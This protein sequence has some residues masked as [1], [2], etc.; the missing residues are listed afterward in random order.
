MARVKNTS[1]PRFVFKKTSHAI[2]TPR[3]EVQTTP[4]APRKRVI[5]VKRKFRH[6]S[7]TVAL[8]EIRKYQKTTELLIQKL[9]FSR[10]VRD[11]LEYVTC[12][13]N[14][15]RSVEKIASETFLI[16]QEASEQ[17]LVNLFEDANL[18]AI[19]AKRKTI[20]KRDI[21]LAQ[22]VYWNGKGIDLDPNVKS[23]P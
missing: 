13:K 20:E 4:V 19:H 23:K 17:F 11:V 9:P 16:L 6:R 22:K 21:V 7:G 14:G 10:L 15:R 8:R 2:K 1:H 12:V 3:K 18:S 5:G